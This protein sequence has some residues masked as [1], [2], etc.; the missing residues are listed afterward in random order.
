MAEYFRD[1]GYETAGFGKTHWG[2]YPTGTRGF[3]TRYTAQI[4]EEGGI[5][6]AQVNP[7]AKARYDAENRT[8]GCR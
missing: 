8:D 3:E 5:S 6:M 4:P 1:A 2:K 7:E